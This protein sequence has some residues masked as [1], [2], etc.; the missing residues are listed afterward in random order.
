MRFP[1]IPQL[2]TTLAKNRYNALSFRSRRYFPVVSF[3]S[4]RGKG[5]TTLPKTNGASTRFRRATMR[6]EANH[7]VSE[8]MWTIE[9]SI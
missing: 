4:H 6:R 9:G 2:L 1:T 7:E 5:L 8:A 3:L